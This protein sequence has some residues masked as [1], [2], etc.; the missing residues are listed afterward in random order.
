MTDRHLRP[1]QLGDGFRY[2]GE[3]FLAGLKTKA[4]LHRIRS[5]TT[6]VAHRHH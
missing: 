5:G 3:Y 2:I 1:V 6:S 4:R